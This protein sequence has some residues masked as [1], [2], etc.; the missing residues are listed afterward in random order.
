VRDVSELLVA[1]GPR[2]AAQVSGRVTYD[3]PC[4]LM[5]AQRI[6]AQPLTVLGAIDKLDF[7]PLDGAEHCCGAA[8]IYN[9]LEPEVS[10]AV[11]APKLREIERTGAT[12]LATGNPG[13]M[14]QIAAGLR[15]SGSATRVLHPVELLDRGYAAAGAYATGHVAMG[16]DRQNGK[17]E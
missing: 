6:A 2:P 16:I 4:H 10:A 17:A 7:V 8:G 5:H 3:A 11:L 14:M 15:R 12:V 9:L 13:C 1:A